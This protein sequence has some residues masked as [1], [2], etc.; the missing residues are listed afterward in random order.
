MKPYLQ[1]LPRHAHTSHRGGSLL[2]PENTLPAFAQ[3]VE[4]YGTHVLELDVQPCADGAVMVFHDDDLDRT[5]NGHGPVRA[6]TQAALQALDAGWHHPAWRGKGATIPTLSQVLETFPR[7]AINI[8]LKQ[9]DDAFVDAFAK[10]IERHHAVDRVCIGHVE[11]DRSQF[12]QARLPRCCFW[13]PQAAIMAFFSGVK[14]Y[15][16]MPAAVPWDVLSVPLEHGGMRVVDQ[17]FVDAAHA[18]HK[19]VHVWT[20]DDVPLMEELWSLGVDSILT[21]RPDLLRDVMD[22]RGWTAVTR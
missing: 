22:R 7:H 9:G 2:A 13:Y 8:E 11:E 16:P 21:D 18:L 12:I 1:A 17:A 10:V 19:V 5:T 3:A 4:K 14:G 6:Q 15:G 20:V